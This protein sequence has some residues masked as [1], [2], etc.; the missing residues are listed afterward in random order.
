MTQTYFVPHYRAYFEQRGIA[1]DRPTL[2]AR[3]FR[4]PN[5]FLAEP[6]YQVSF[7]SEICD[8]VL[9]AL[10]DDTSMYAEGPGEHGGAVI[11]EG[12]VVFDAGAN[13]GL[14]SMV[15]ASRASRVIAFE[16]IPS[17]LGMLEKARALHPNLEIAPF[18]LASAPGEAEFHLSQGTNTCN[19]MVMQKGTRSCRV[20]THSIDAFVAE[21]GI[22]RIDFIKADIEG[23]ERDM[24]AGAR[25]TLRD[26]APRLS[27]CTYHLPDDPEVLESLIR[28]ANPA[29]TIEH[30]WAKLYAWVP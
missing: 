26:H 23:A 28:Q 30:R 13:I 8:Y 12:D 18:A 29:Y 17:V 4:F 16:P 3:G 14:F 25:K 2:A 5:P 21:R 19:S 10:C 7:F 22:H 1:C 9:P 11:R 6:D 27:I 15:A 24:L 20:R